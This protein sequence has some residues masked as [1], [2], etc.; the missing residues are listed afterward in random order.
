MAVLPL[1]GATL[2]PVALVVFVVLAPVALVVF[3]GAAP[4]ANAP[5]ILLRTFGIPN[6]PNPTNKEPAPIS[7]MKSL[8]ET[9]IFPKLSCTNAAIPL[10]LHIY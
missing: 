3:V 9:P 4:C 6:A 10:D 5:L 7:F 8:L 2:A 1:V